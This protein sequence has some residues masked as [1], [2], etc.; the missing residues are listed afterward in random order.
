MTV[1]KVKEMFA[2]I[3]GNIE[4]SE[5]NSETPLSD[6]GIESL[7]TF[8]FFLQVEEDFGVVISDDKMGDLNTVQKIVDYVNEH[9]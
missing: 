4:A 2:E 1:E 3:N 7:D 6:Q 9:S 5:L 8:D